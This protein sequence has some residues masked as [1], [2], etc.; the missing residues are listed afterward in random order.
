MYLLVLIALVDWLYFYLV[1]KT[2]RLTISLAI[3][4]I[5]LIGDK[6]AISL[7]R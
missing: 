3:S 5:I 1:V 2:L 4:S 7:L 6:V